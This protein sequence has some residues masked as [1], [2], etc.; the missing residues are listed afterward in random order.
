MSVGGNDRAVRWDTYADVM[1]G[2][3]PIRKDV[4]EKGRQVTILEHEVEKLK[5]ALDEKESQLG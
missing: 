2:R 4:A 5:A 1:I 3:L